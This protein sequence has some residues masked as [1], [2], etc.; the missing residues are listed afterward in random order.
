VRDYV[1]AWEARDIDRLAALLKS[2]VVVTM[3]PFGL[4]L[5]GKEAAA[6][7]LALIWAA[8]PAGETYLAP[9]RANRQ[10]AF[11]HYRPDASSG[12]CLTFGLSVLTLDGDAIAELTAFA[13]PSL[14]PWFAFPARLPVPPPSLQ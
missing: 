7:F 4:R 11:A 6:R 3:P 12:D 13:D 8:I 5:V 14:V 1:E 2:D 10:C 9:T